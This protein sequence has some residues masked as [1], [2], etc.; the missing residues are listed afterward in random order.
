[1][2]EASAQD[3][4]LRDWLAVIRCQQEAGER[5]IREADARILAMEHHLAATR[6]LRTE[7]FGTGA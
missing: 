6:A 3:Q 1:M 4:M 2:D 5:T 7:Y